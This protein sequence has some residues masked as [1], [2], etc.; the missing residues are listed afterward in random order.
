MKTQAHLDRTLE[1]TLE[2]NATPQEV[3]DAI[4]TADG[5][6]SWFS[7]D[8]KVIPGNEGSI[9]LAWGPDCAGEVPITIWE[10]LHRLRT[11]EHRAPYGDPSLPPVDIN[12]QYTIESR[13]GKTILTLVHSGMGPEAG[14]DGEYHATAA[15]WPWFLQN[16][17]HLVEVHPGVVRE[18][19]SF[20]VPFKIPGAELWSMALDLGADAGTL[21]EGQPYD[22]KLFGRQA[23]NGVV[24]MLN[25][26]KRFMGTIDAMNQAMLVLT[27][28]DKGE[29]SKLEVELSTFNVDEADVKR[30]KQD[31]LARLK[32]LGGKIARE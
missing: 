15:D 30:T 5:L 4:A 6:K 25:P 23:L 10:P 14:W 26:E 8:A 22:L 21:R 27:V 24:K 12:V 18:V 32:E 28:R 13:E 19:V 9:W 7:Y 16:L 1:Y 31:W 2:L 3:W 11:T 17:Q 20:A 29:S